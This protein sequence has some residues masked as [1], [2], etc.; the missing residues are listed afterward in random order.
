MRCFTIDAHGTEINVKIL[1]LKRELTMLKSSFFY[2]KEKKSLSCIHYFL[3]RKRFLGLKKSHRCFHLESITFSFTWVRVI[4][5]GF[6][7]SEKT[8]NYP[9]VM[10]RNSSNEGWRRN[11]T[12]G[13]VK[14]TCDDLSVLH[15]NKRSGSGKKGMG[16]RNVLR[17]RESFLFFSACFWKS[18]KQIILKC[19]VKL[20][21]I[22][23]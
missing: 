2:Y 13:S 22:T 17:D 8:A 18:R 6:T 10:D 3:D 14:Q 4:H 20:D 23:D 5:P 19:H 15:L 16:M 11:T 9:Q 7:A 1:H 12:D 21:L